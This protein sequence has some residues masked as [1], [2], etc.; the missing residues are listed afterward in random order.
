[1][2]NPTMAGA[3]T[4]PSCVA[5]A[6]APL[7]AGPLAVLGLAGVGAF[8]HYA[9]AFFAPLNVAVVALGYR[10][11]RRPLPL[12]I[13]IAGLAFLVFHGLTV[14]RHGQTIEIPDFF[15]VAGVTLVLAATGLDWISHRSS[16]FAAGC[17]TAEEYWRKLARGEHPGVRS[18]RRLL[19]LLPSSPRCVLCNAPFAGVGAVVMRVAGKPR[20][21]KNPRFCAICLA[22]TPPGGAEVEASLLFVDVRGST[23][24]AEQLGDTRYAELINRFYV[25]AT[26]VLVNSDALVIDFVGDEVVALYLPGFAGAEHARRAAEAAFELLRV[27]G[28]AADDPWIPIGVGVHTGTAYVGA[29][30]TPG[31]VTDLRAMGDAVNTTARLTAEAKAGTVVISDAAA[32]ASMIPLMDLDQCELSLKGKSQTVAA[33]VSRGHRNGE[34]GATMT[35]SK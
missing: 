33:W 4:A 35:A 8:L 22:K 18:G 3:I 6:G 30:G 31:S 5:C 29:V 19:R 24:F 17:A 14:H 13:G 27:T 16:R 26:E 11:H 7:L 9:L 32:R 1:M 12:V 25:A 28:H 10:V 20:S 15:A 23:A 34:A 21:A 2:A